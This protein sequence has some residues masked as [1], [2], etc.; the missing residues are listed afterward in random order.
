MKAAM[1]ANGVSISL[2]GGFVIRGRDN[3]LPDDP[4]VPG[5]IEMKA[6][7]AADLDSMADL[8][9]KRVNAVCVDRDLPRSFDQ[10]GIFAELSAARGMESTIEFCPVLGI[11]DLPTAVRAVRHVNLLAFKLLL[12][13]MHLYR[14]G[15][16]AA[17][18]SALD[19]GIIGHAQL[20]DVPRVAANSSYVD[21]AMYERMAP[22]TGGLPL[23]EYLDALPRQ[24]IIGLEVPQRSLAEAGV[25]P[26]DRV[27]R[28]VDGARA[29]MARISKSPIRRECGTTE[30]TTEWIPK[31]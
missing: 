21:E 26:R 1:K 4:F 12:D 10:L 14:S 25:A 2:G 7:W 29:L 30:R 27:S 9:I 3:A 8:G 19:P 31:Y 24:V 16:S 20:C 17:D 11:A 13:P 28:A 18:I 22:G 23:L 5:E 6:R 15:G